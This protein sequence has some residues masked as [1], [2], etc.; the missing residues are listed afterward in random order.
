MKRI[1]WILLG[2]FAALLSLTL[3]LERKEPEAI[4]PSAI[5]DK[6]TIFLLEKKENTPLIFL[7]IRRG[8][9]IFQMARGEDGFWRVDLPEGVK[10][11]EL[12]VLESAASQVLSIPLEEADLSL[13]WE[14]VAGQ[15][16]DEIACVTVRYA[17]E[18]ASTFLVG[19]L[20]HSGNGYYVQY[21]GKIG[22]IAVNNFN[23]LFQLFDLAS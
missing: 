8:D 22:I 12:G 23:V 15:N 16:Q 3:L 5:Q 21:E 20:T 6:E 2:V 18:M 19:G 13:D 1:S 17:D 11:V 4:A 10:D 7:D 9:D 14:D